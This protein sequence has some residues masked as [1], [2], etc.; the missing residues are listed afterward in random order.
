MSLDIFWTFYIWLSAKQT[1]KPD[2]QSRQ[3]N[4][5]IKLYFN[6]TFKSLQI[7]TLFANS[8]A[9]RNNVL[10]SCIEKVS[11]KILKR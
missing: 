8:V 3:I 10:Y 4:N 11:K 9:K 7:Q 6:V 1:D 5:K 2:K